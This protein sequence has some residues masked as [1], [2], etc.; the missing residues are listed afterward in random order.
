MN[1]KLHEIITNLSE[2]NNKSLNKNLKFIVSAILSMTG[3]VTMLN[4]A[5]WNNKYSYKTIDRFFTKKINW[6]K[7]NYQISKT[8]FGK[9]L[10]LAGDEVIITKSGKHTFGLGKNYS[11]ILNIPVKSIK[12]LTISIIDVERKRSFPLLI[13]QLHNKKKK[14][15]KNKE[16]KKSKKNKKTG[17]PKGSLNKNSKDKIRLTGLFRVV[18]FCLKYIKKVIKLP[19]IKYF[20]YDGAFGNRQGIKAVEDE[21]FFLISK[22]RYDSSLYFKFKGKQKQ[23]GRPRIYG[24]KVNYQNLDSKYLKEKKIKKG[25]KNIELRTYQ[26]LAYN[27]KISGPLN[28]VVLVVKNLVTGKEGHSIIFSKDQHQ[29]YEKIIQYYSS[30]FQIEFNFRD[31]KQFFGL[32]D[33]MN[34]KKR[35]IHNFANLSLFMNNISFSLSKNN[36]DK[37]YSVNN[38][39]S[40]FRTEKYLD[41]AL[42]YYGEKG[43]MFLNQKAINEIS[44][45]SMIYRSSA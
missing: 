18:N 29:S 42:K 5:R 22:L 21:G 14:I 24:E 40:L 23:K 43:E 13:K 35:K 25:T 3:R 10:I 27:Q 11:S 45:F 32:E 41:E 15:V 20:V 34:I 28:I 17:R 8:F 7:I 6:V 33:F 39:K 37:Q 16:S 19:N 9:D 2:I 31:S 44:E 30:R 1:Q 12:C 4:I 38:L 26:F 36:E